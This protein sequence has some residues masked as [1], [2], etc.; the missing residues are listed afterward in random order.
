MPRSF[1]L[2]RIRGVTRDPRLYLRVILG[3]LLAANLGAALVAFKPWGDS[4]EE[5]ERKVSAMRTQYVQRQ[6]ALERLKALVAKSDKARTEGE[7]FLSQ[8]FMS[9]RTASSTIVNELVSIAK[10]TGIKPKEHSFLFEPVEGSDTLSAMTITA[11]YE[12]TYAD[13]MQ[14]VN[15]LDRSPRFLIVESMQAAPQQGQ[16]GVLNITVKLM[17]FVREEAAQP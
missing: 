3:V 17:A 10:E 7:K 15:K 14:Y 4:P 1:D 5:V 9:R 8:Y 12:G 6:A 16:T 2:G 13:L 11:G